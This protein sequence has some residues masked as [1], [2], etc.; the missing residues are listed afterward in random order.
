MTVRSLIFL[1]AAMSA[2]STAQV[3]ATGTWETFTEL[4]TIR[5]VVAGSDG[6]VSAA[7]GGGLFTFHPL[8]RAF[9]IVTNAQG[10]AS[11]DLTTLAVDSRRG[12]WVGASDGALNHR[13]D[14]SATWR[15]LTDIRESNRL[16]KGIQRLVPHGDTLFIVSQFGVSVYR[17]DRRE[18]ADTYAS[19]GYS[20]PPICWDVAIANDTVWVATDQGIAAAS[21]FAPNL[22]APTSW[23]RF[24]T[25]DGLPGLAVRTLV[26]YRDTLLAGTTVGTGVRVGGRFLPQPSLAAHRSV[27][28]ALRETSIVVLTIESG[29][30]VVSTLAGALADR[31]VVAP[32]APGTAVDVAP[33]AGSGAVWLGL[34][35]L[36]VGRVAGGAWDWHVPNAPGSNLFVS[37]SVDAQG[38]L[39]AATGINGGGRGFMRFRREGDD[40]RRWK[41]FTAATDPI[42]I[43]NDYYKVNPSADGSMW[44]SSWGEGVVRVVDDSIRRRIS[45]Q[46][47]P[48]LAP[49]VVGNP[50]FVVVGGVAADPQGRLWFVNRTAVDGNI[51][52]RLDSDS[53]FTMFRNQTGT[54]EGR[55]ASVVIDRFGTKWLGNSEPT[56]K[57]SSGL[58]YF[59]ESGQL[60]GTSTTGGWGLLTQSDGLPNNTVISL[61]VDLEGDVWVGTDLGVAIFDEPSNPRIRRSSSFPLREQSIQCIAVDGVNNKWVGTKEG[62]FVVSPDG[63]QLV[64]QYTVANTGGKLVANDVR[65]VAIDQRQGIVY[66]GTEQGLSALAIAAVQMERRFTALSVGPN[67]Y[68][69][70]SPDLLTIR[71]LVP[72]TRIKILG[73]TGSLVAE[74]DAQGGGRAFWDGRDRD[75]RIVGSGTY[76]IV[77]F[78]EN[79]EQIIT[80]KVA[81]I[82]R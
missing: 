51:L 21:L 32:S 28:M 69:I 39:W 17:V 37:L 11:N 48:A 76:V 66:F 72:Q 20:S 59:N 3:P 14:G 12:L 78:N 27:R 43:F 65:S 74:F 64:A 5:A 40:D 42:L 81:V 77:A 23:V 73:I 29:Q 35:G 75:G 53:A 45:T 68:R 22:S 13:P 7:T 36:G 15:T 55:F 33:G 46:S 34:P 61:A 44:V 70:P 24:G 4:S 62:V 38:I 25:G 80:A 50:T 9:E 10:L 41:T 30:T 18:F 1:A 47:T 79:G 49:T 71:N 67:P 6:S 56:A 31:S 26:T 52:A 8:T 2:T 58:Y 54:G 57:A 63:S 16:L 60:P 19:F 82:R